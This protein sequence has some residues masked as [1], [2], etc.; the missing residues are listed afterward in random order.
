[1]PGILDIS[2]ANQALAL[3]Y[4]LVMRAEL[5][6]EVYRIPEDIDREIAALNLGGNWPCC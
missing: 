5:K 6:R 1:V 2:F 3:E 4:L